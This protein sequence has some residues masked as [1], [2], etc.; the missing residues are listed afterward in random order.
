[1]ATT[2]G[3]AE[4]LPLEGKKGRKF[5]TVGT[6]RYTGFGLIMIFVWLLWGDF[7]W[8]VFDNGIPAILPLKLHELGA[9]DTTIAFLNKTLAYAISFFFSPMVSFHSDRYRSRLGRRI[10]YLLW[11]TP[12][13]GLFL[14]LIGCYDSVTNV[15][16]GQASSASILGIDVGR[17]TLTLVVFGALFVGFDLANIFVN[18]VY[19]YLFNDVVPSQYLSRF[20]SFF[21][22]TGTLAGVFYNLYIFPQAMDNFRAVFVAGGIIYVIGFMIMCAMVR[23]GKYPPPPEHVDKGTGFLSAMKTFAKECFTHKFYWYFFITST[24]TFLSYQSG[25]FGLLRSTTTLGLTLAQ[26]GLMGA[27]IA[28]A[29]FALQYPAGWMADKYHP[30]RVNLIASA[31]CL[32][33]TAAGCIFMFWD[34]GTWGNLVAMYAMSIVFLPFRMVAGAAEIPMYMRVLPKERYGQFCSAN[35]MVRSF[36]LIFGALLAGVFMDYVGS[37]PCRSY[38][39]STGEIQST[40]T[41]KPDW[42]EQPVG[43]WAASWENSTAG[44]ITV[45]VPGATAVKI[46]FSEINPGSKLDRVTTDAVDNGTDSWTSPAREVYSRGRSGP[47]ITILQRSKSPATGSVVI[48]R[49]DWQGT[50]TGEIAFEGGAKLATFPLSGVVTNRETGKGLPGVK[51]TFKREGWLRRMFSLSP[52]AV[53]TDDSGCWRQTG[54][55]NG[56]R[57]VVEMS[58]HGEGGAWTFDRDIREVGWALSGDNVAAAWRPDWTEESVGPWRVNYVDS[59]RLDGTIRVPGAAKIKVLFSEVAPEPGGFDNLTTDAGTP[60]KPNRWSGERWR[61]VWSAEK[62]GDTIAISQVAGRPATGNFVVKKVAWTAH[63]TGKMTREGA[64]WRPSDRFPL[65]GRVVSTADGKGVPGVAISFRRDYSWW[66]NWALSAPASVK[67]DDNGRWKQTGFKSGSEYRVTLSKEQEGGAWLFSPASVGATGAARGIAMATWVTPSEWT[68][69]S[70]PTQLINYAGKFDRK[71]SIIVPGAKDVIVYFSSITT[72]PGV[73]H[74]T[75]D[76]GASDDWSG[77]FSG[78]YSNVKPGDN[79]TLRLATGEKG[80]GTLMVW[81]V[82]YRGKRTGPVRFEGPLWGFCLSGKVRPN[83]E[84]RGMPGV[85]VSFRRVGGSGAVP[86]P[87]VTD[88]DGKWKQEGFERGSSYQVDL[89]RREA[90]GSWEFSRPTMGDWH[91]RWFPV[92]TIIFQVLALISLF[93]L[94][95]EWKKLGGDENYVPPAA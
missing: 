50:R 92:W 74:L 9:G 3:I 35:D 72:E 90:E 76:A 80:K 70:L 29:V 93:L 41:W 43:P 83:G 45:T 33:S 59:M 87:V 78:I 24:F 91:Y 55:L 7:V 4:A 15:F 48:S 6:L 16:I 73:D 39:A 23:E 28:P 37:F 84:D 81:K 94:Y 10:P 36:A 89:A 56:T 86:P 31:I 63:A 30:L 42:N 60:D 17:A 88:K 12:F 57:Y 26:L 5:Y 58:K 61:D 77:S 34:F 18:N 19:W 71:G 52:D 1:M 46:Y 82:L 66:I 85:T 2:E 44:A 20:M 53:V 65:S 8:Q 25:L 64:L 32:V 40:A 75:T 22:M 54:F 38:V 79:I 95:R 67:T 14:I 69:E 13:V 27:L 47:T 49:V 68:E 21:R 51:V 62:T 11:S